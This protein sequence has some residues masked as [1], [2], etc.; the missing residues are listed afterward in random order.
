MHTLTQRAVIEQLDDEQIAIT[1]RAAADALLLVWP[2]IDR[3]TD[4]AAV[5]RANST[6]VGTRCSTALWEPHA[7]E[8]L[9]K[10]GNSLG[11]AGHVVAARNYYSNL[12]DAAAHH[13]G[14]RNTDYLA[15]IAS[16]AHWRGEAGDPLGATTALEAVLS[17]QLTLLGPNHP[18][19]LATRAS[20]AR[21]R[22]EGGDPVAAIAVYNEVLNDQLVSGP[23]SAR[24]THPGH[25]R[26]HRPL[27]W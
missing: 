23:G 16:F 26:R 13:L 27:A 25:P 5:L 2:E 24:P 6:T 10:T 15:V 4:L 19:T 7:H 9:F 17:D 18:Q 11:N 21:W 3:D 12:V 22:G 14:S 8:L 20:I 1:V